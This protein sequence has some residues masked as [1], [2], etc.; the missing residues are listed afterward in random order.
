MIFRNDGYIITNAHV[1]KGADPTNITVKLAD[2]REFRHVQL[3]G[4]DEGTDIA[5][6]KVNASNL[7][8]VKLAIHPQ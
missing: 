3:V 4:I 2:D 5:V 8:V 7:P 1:V 6:L